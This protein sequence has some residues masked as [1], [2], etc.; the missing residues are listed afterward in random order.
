MLGSESIGFEVLGAP[1]SAPVVFALSSGRGSAP[2]GPC[3][4]LLAAPLT[5]LA[6]VANAAGVAR[7]PVFSAPP[8]PSLRGVML[9]GQGFVVDPGAPRGGSLAATRGLELRFGD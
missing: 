7:T 3:R 4:L 9:V 8:D 5:T 2:V 1:P 6:V